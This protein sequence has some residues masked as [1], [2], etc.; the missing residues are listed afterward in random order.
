MYSF[1]VSSNRAIIEKNI[2]L[3]HDLKEKFGF[4]YVV[5]FFFLT[6]YSSNSVIA[7]RNIYPLETSSD[8]KARLGLKALA[9]TWLQRAQAFKKTKPGFQ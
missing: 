7:V 1:V 5:H 4:L 3:A 6:V 9:R 8:V 2:K